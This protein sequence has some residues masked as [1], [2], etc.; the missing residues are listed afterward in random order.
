MSTPVF[1]DYSN[2]AT[3]I[4]DHAA[5]T[6]RAVAPATSLF[7]DLKAEAQKELDT[8]VTF[9]VRGREGYTITFDSQISSKEI[10]RWSKNAQGK[11]KRAEDADRRLVAGA[12]IV[13][14]NTGI[15]K[16]GEPVVDEEGDILTFRSWP[17]IDLFAGDNAAPTSIDSVIK[18]MGEGQ[19]FSLN[20][21]LLAEAGYGDDIAPV[22]P[23]N[24]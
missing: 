14:K 1:G 10:V 23:T 8:D 15:Y 19:M 2:E 9:A 5:A 24:G 22:D 13:E 3:T 11:K 4:P 17:F 21:A 6:A 16:N 18:F 12:C 7:D 20:D